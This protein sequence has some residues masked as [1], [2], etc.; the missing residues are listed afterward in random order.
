MDGRLELGSNRLNDTGSRSTYRAEYPALENLEPTQLS[1][2]AGLRTEKELSDVVA[3]GG[4]L[5]RGTR[6]P[7]HL[8]RYGYYIY[9]PLDGYFYIGNPGLE[10]ELSS[11]AELYTV[12]GSGRSAISGRVAVWVNRMEN[13]VAGERFDDLFKRH[14]N[15]G[16]ATLWGSEAEMSIE[17]SRNWSLSGTL[18][19]ILG[20][21]S[22]LDEPLPMI[23][24]LRGSASLNRNFERADFEM[25]VRWSATQERVADRNHLEERTPGHTV[26]DLF[27]RVNLS[28]AL[29][30]QLGVENLFNTH[31]A[32][33]LSVNA[34][35]EPG[36][37][38]QVSLIWRI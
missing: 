21:H 10:P 14:D 35:P 4:R 31:F 34:F 7:D 6:L 15:M 2:L 11:Q 29:R 19:W 33:H 28:S 37:N 27:G 30:L 18:S 20:Y 26:L 12:F 38:L 3:I 32:D 8:E 13:Y 17:M 16:I 24:P 9:Q 36:R 25:R 23:P 22:E 5:S 1:W